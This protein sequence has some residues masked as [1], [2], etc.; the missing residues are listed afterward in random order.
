MATLMGCSEV[1][2]ALSAKA[3]VSEILARFAQVVWNA[4]SLEEIRYVEKTDNE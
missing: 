4:A 1:W 3:S 2:R